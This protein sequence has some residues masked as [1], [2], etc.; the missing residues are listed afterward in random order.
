MSTT[1]GTNSASPREFDELAPLPGNR[2]RRRWWLVLLLMAAL[3]AYVL[4]SGTDDQR[5]HRLAQRHLSGH[6]SPVP[7][8]FVFLLDESGSFDKYQQIRIG[9]LS[10]ILVWAPAN[11]RPNDTITVIGFSGDAY[12]KLGPVTVQSL[13]NNSPTVASQVPTDS[14]NIRPALELAIRT[15]KGRPTT[16]VAVTDTLM[17]D[18]ASTPIVRYLTALNATDMSVILPSGAPLDRGWASAFDFEQVIHA[19][20][21]SAD[22]TA[23]ALGRAVA[24][25]TH[26]KLIKN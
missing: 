20:P 11:L 2:S 23:L 18:T 17:A 10:Q 5:P 16:L 15:S 9:M 26:Q 21:G 6:R 24:S 14:T 8:A 25:G 3:L 19:Q 13:T 4:G 1:I 12:L 7:H 22:E